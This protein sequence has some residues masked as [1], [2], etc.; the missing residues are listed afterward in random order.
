M[1]TTLRVNGG[2]NLG[3]LAMYSLKTDCRVAI[4]DLRDLFHQ[5]NVPIELIPNPL[6]DLGAFQRATTAVASKVV[7][8]DSPIICKE[9]KNDR[10]LCI[11]TFEKR[12]N[13][14]QTE[15]ETVEQGREAIPVYT[16]VAT[17]VYHK[18][19]QSIDRFVLYP[20]GQAVVDKALDNYNLIS[21]WYHIE[22][23]RKMIQIVFNTYG[24]IDLRRN[25]GCNFIPECHQE[26]FERFCKV[27]DSLEGVQ[28]IT[29]DIKFTKGNHEAITEALQSHINE[30]LEDEIK[31]L[32]S[33][34]VGNVALKD[35]VVDFTQ[36]L[37][38]GKI[39]KAGLNSLMN[40]FNH[41]MKIVAEYKDL[42]QVD[43]EETESQIEI[44][45]KQVGLLLKRY[46]EEQELEDSK[47]IVEKIMEKKFG[48][49]A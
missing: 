26:E 5:N 25:G 42:L 28:I 36:A 16:H 29:L 49:S 22:Q 6:S 32:G 23:I 39:H 44:A 14:S 43:L 11:R 3:T 8:T 48:K 46:D 24:A 2:S 21:G 17:M 1:T 19:S 15:I 38:G 37:Y 7:K 41:T 31:S 47:D 12:T 40:K 30:S 20:C 18:N 33:K 10:E 34:T 45:K 13:E 27:C 4:Q 9:I 35:L